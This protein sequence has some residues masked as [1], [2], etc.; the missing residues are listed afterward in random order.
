M[1]DKDED[2]EKEHLYIVIKKLKPKPKIANRL[3]I[4]SDFILWKKKSSS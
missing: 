2:D 3:S 4:K 1:I